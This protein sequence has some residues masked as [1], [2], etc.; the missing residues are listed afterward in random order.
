MVLFEFIGRILGKALYEVN[1]LTVIYLVNFF[2]QGIVVDVQFAHFFLSQILDHHM[3]SLYSSLD[4]LVSLDPDLHRSL[5][6]IK[7]FIS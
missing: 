5:L 2:L 1:F 6:S 3:S 4:E 7:V